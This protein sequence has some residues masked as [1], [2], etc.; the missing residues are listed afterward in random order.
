MSKNL[1]DMCIYLVAINV[2]Q[3]I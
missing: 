3:D 2:K 1:D